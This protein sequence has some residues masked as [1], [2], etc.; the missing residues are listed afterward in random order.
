VIFD[1][2]IFIA[3]LE[4]AGVF[5]VLLLILLPALMTW[6]IRK[7]KHDGE[8]YQVWGGK[9]IILLTLAISLVLLVVAF[10]QA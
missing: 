9:L 4:Y 8:V 5:C 7:K 10:C 3:A 2:S 6:Q 1:P